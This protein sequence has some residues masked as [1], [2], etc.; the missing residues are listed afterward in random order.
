MH[1]WYGS[2]EGN[3]I[4]VV[5]MNSSEHDQLIHL[6]K[7]PRECGW[8]ML[9]YSG[10]TES[11][12]NVWNGIWKSPSLAL[13]LSLV[14]HKRG[15]GASLCS[16]TGK[17]QRSAEMLR[18]FALAV[19]VPSSHADSESPWWQA[20]QKVVCDM[21][22]DP[23]HHC[24]SL[25]LSPMVPMLTSLSPFTFCLSELLLRL[26]TADG[27]LACEDCGIPTRVISGGGFKNSRVFAPVVQKG[28]L[29]ASPAF[30]K[31]VKDL[32]PLSVVFF[33]F[34]VIETEALLS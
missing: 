13:Y 30:G 6:R 27:C 12:G 28:V 14:P 23:H 18:L 10:E 5:L 11:P 26:H 2:R 1:R 3:W 19:C 16:N 15:A 7:A 21:S 25:S 31:K 29:L 34:T 32:C 8:W 33:G 9:S 20:K 17:A 4:S 22:T 24:L